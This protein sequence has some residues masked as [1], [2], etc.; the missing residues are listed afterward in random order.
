MKMNL[1]NGTYAETRTNYCI[2]WITTQ[3]RL[4]AFT[5]R[6]VTMTH[7]PGWLVRVWSKC[8]LRGHPVRAS[9]TLISRS[10]GSTWGGDHWSQIRIIWHQCRHQWRFILETCHHSSYRPARR[11]PLN[12]L[13]IG[14]SPRNLWRHRFRW[15]TRLKGMWQFH[16]VI[17]VDD[18]QNHRR[19][20]TN[21][22]KCWW[23][24]SSSECA[25][26]Q[27]RSQMSLQHQNQTCA[28]RC[29]DSDDFLNKRRGWDRPNPSA[30]ETWRRN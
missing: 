13:L 24:T 18:C 26:T 1:P 14:L 10:R 16:V 30:F 25:L 11:R 4:R 22:T 9:S 19:R 8:L 29:C 23:A 27:V 21:W 6:V 5:P 3:Y 20:V 7:R 2:A 15:P 12:T 17:K 28:L